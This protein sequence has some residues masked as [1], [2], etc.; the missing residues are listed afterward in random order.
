M[1][2]LILVAGIVV[3]ILNL[4]ANGQLP[5]AAIAPSSRPGAGMPDRDFAPLPAPVTA[6][7]FS[8]DG[9]LAAAGLANG[10]VRVWDLTTGKV[11]FSIA[12]HVRA[13]TDIGFTNDG[14]RLI[15]ASV[16]DA[17]IRVWDVAT[18]DLLNLIHMPGHNNIGS[19]AIS[20]DGSHF[21]GGTL[22]CSGAWM[23]DIAKESAIYHIDVATRANDLCFTP[24]GKQLLIFSGAQMDLTSPSTDC[25][26]SIHNADT[27]ERIARVNIPELANSGRVSN[28]GRE[29]GV[30]MLSL[31]KNVFAE[32][33]DAETR[34]VVRRVTSADANHQVY[35]FGA[36]SGDLNRILSGSRSDP[37]PV[38]YD[39]ESG[40]PIMKI[41]IGN[42]AINRL[43]VSSDG[44][45][46]LIATGGAAAAASGADAEYWPNWK[47]KGINGVWLRRITPMSDEE[48]DP[49]EH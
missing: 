30:F 1:R 25:A 32:I 4:A 45:Y 24:D 35:S 26:V 44:E 49:P 23:F 9:R 29:I 3:L 38:V 27:G 21:A 13:V 18:G 28:D 7:E 48:L 8:H 47:P 6:I 31:H 42:V 5:P 15:S 16:L 39:T 11:V 36:F 22:S 2:R 41:R 40:K 20:P 14:K 10:T 37:V 43:R 34:K 19:M 46:A 17:R 12:G 33:L